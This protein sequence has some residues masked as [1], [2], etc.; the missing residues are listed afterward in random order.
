MK[1]IFVAYTAVMLDIYLKFLVQEKYIHEEILEYSDISDCGVFKYKD[2]NYVQ[3]SLTQSIRYVEEYNSKFQK[4]LKE[5]PTL[6]EKIK[7]SDPS[8]FILNHKLDF[9]HIYGFDWSKV[10][11]YLRKNRNRQHSILINYLQ[12]LIILIPTALKIANAGYKLEE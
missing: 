11:D 12:K 5:Q 10:L 4:I 3:F 2:N 7:S 9:L 8:I 6:K 1:H